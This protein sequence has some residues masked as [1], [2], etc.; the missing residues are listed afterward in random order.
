MRAL[1]VS[2]DKTYTPG[3]SVAEIHDHAVGEWPISPAEVSDAALLVPVA[4]GRPV[5][6]AWQV[7]GAIHGASA[8]DGAPRTIVVTMGHAVRTEG[9]VAETPELHDG[10]A[11]ADLVLAA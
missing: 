2:I 1:F 8:T 10:V 7:R 9:L 5:G 3:D 6:I 11:M 4:D